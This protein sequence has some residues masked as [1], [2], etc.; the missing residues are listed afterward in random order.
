MN[1][2]NRSFSIPDCPRNRECRERVYCELGLNLLVCQFDCSLNI[3]CCISNYFWLDGFADFFQVNNFQRVFDNV[4]GKSFFVYGHFHL[5]FFVFGRFHFFA[6]QFE[7]D[8]V[9]KQLFFLILG[10]VFF[11]CCEL[12]SSFSLFFYNQ[13]GFFLESTCGY[14]HFYRD[15]THSFFKIQFRS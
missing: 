5:H 2:D 15:L 3:G 1:S 10:N 6:I 13:Y 14:M 9:N 12:C 8:V 7:A 4:I 11:G